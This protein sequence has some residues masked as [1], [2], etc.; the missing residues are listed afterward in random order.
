M[1]SA[2]ATQRT[3]NKICFITASQCCLDSF[4]KDLRA[5]FG[6]MQ[7]LETPLF[8][9]VL[10]VF[11]ELCECNT[12]STERLHSRNSRRVH[13]RAWT[14]ELQLA[15]AAVH[16]NG[17]ACPD[18]L[19]E[20]L[21][22]DMKSQTDL[23]IG[24]KRKHSSVKKRKKPHAKRR[25]G[26]GGSWRAFIHLTSLTSSGKLDLQHCAQ[27]YRQLPLAE[28]ER[29]QSIGELATTLHRDG[30]RSFPRTYLPSARALVDNAAAGTSEPSLS[31]LLDCV[32]R[33]NEACSLTRYGGG[34]PSAGRLGLASMNC[35]HH[36]H[37]C[38]KTQVKL[39]CCQKRCICLDIF[40][41]QH[42]SLFVLRLV[43]DLVSLPLTTA[44]A[45]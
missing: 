7:E 14:H 44:I 22:R 10:K 33:G 25:R 17:M 1:L 5:R 45:P 11:A 38:I 27:L 24:S 20:A 30:V 37:L 4:S 40:T 9:T 3:E 42:E 28:K 34:G 8:E 41:S 2:D 18:F 16:H 31:S 23:L 19:K 12:Y 6:A 32:G 39:G 36:E 21:Q 13:A 26:G 43:F 35:R 29:L 15:Q